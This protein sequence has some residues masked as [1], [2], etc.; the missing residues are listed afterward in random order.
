MGFA[1]KLIYQIDSTSTGL[2]STLLL[3]PPKNNFGVRTQFSCPL[4]SFL[5]ITDDHNVEAIS[6]VSSCLGL[7]LGSFPIVGLETHI[8]IFDECKLSALC[9]TLV[10]TNTNLLVWS[11]FPDS[12]T[13]IKL[14]SFLELL[15]ESVSNRTGMFATFSRESHAFDARLLSLRASLFDVT[16]STVATINE[17]QLTFSGSVKLYKKYRASLKVNIQQ[18]TDWKNA[19]IQVSGRFLNRP[20]N[21]PELLCEEISRYI[22]TLYHRS[23][24]RIINSKA[25]YDRAKS[26]YLSAEST[27]KTTEATMNEA[28]ELVQQTEQ[29]LIMIQNTVQALSNELRDGNTIVKSIKR[30]IESICNITQCPEICIPRQVCDEC[31][32][33]IS[34]LIQDTCSVPCTKNEIV[35]ITTGIEKKSRMEYVQQENCPNKIPCHVFIC[36]TEEHCETVHISKNITYDSPVTETIEIEILRTC[37]KPCDKVQVNTS[38]LIQCCKNVECADTKQEASCLQRNQQCKHTREVVYINLNE[39]ESATTQLLQSLDEAKANETVTKLRLTR[40][41]IRYQYCKKQ[42]NQSKVALN[43]A[44]TTLNVAAAS[45]KMIRQNNQLDLLDYLN[46]KSIILCSFSDPSYINIKS[47]TFVTNITTES[48]MILA[49]NIEIKIS[50]VR[51]T[52]SETIYLDFDRFNA[53]LKQAVLTIVNNVILNQNFKSKHHRRNIINAS[54]EDENYLH[55]QGQCSDIKNI[56]TYLRE[57]NKSITTIATTAKS[58]LSSLSKNMQEI[59]ALINYTTTTI[60]HENVTLDVETIATLTNRTRT[61]LNTAV[62]IG[63][64]QEIAEVLKLMEEHLFNGQ[65]RA[66]MLDENLFQSWQAKMEL[67]H[68]DTKS[69]AGF[70]CFGF[71]DC[72]QEVVEKL[73]E[74]ISEVPMINIEIISIV[75]NAAED[76]L[77]LA[78]LQNYSIISAQNK[79]HSIYKLA[80]DP[81]LKNYWC[82]G[83]PVI[84]SI[85]P[86]KRTNP[87]EN[88]AVVLSCEVEVQEH[89]SY[90][91]RKDCIQIPNQRNNELLLT[92]LKL[93]DSGNY[94]CVVTNQVSSVTSTNISVEV[95]QFPSFFLQPENVDEFLGN[96]NGAV[97]KS[98]ATG[99]PYP[100]YRWYFQPKG[101]LGFTRM[102]GEDQNELSIVPPLPKHEGSYYCEAFNEQGVVRS[103]IVNLTVLQPTVAQVAQTVYVNFTYLNE[104]EKTKTFGSGSGLTITEIPSAEFSGSGDITEMEKFT[105][106]FT[107]SSGS[108]EDQVKLL[109]SGINVNITITPSTKLMLERNLVNVLSVLMSFESTLVQN[110]TFHSASPFTL[111]TSFTLYSKNIDYSETSLSEINQL[112]SQARLEWAA[113]WK[114]LQEVLSVSGFIISD[115]S[116]EFESNASSLRFDML[117]FVC[118]A[119]KAISPIN[120]LLCGK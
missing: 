70:S 56:L 67:L 120:N 65:Q 96:Q 12:V 2:F 5:F 23:Q 41:K 115:D 90:Q 89:V 114:E 97:I 18:T 53:S 79:M 59:S 82:A 15:P 14:G 110:I 26:Q 22:E 19:E 6:I 118:P 60:L 46:N 71:P 117:Q 75:P 50:S 3:V 36:H 55:F 38:L 43:D 73:Q 7:R 37:N 98:N 32:Q 30:R 74:M 10:S 113:V 11:T 35:T 86:I 16:F 51:K 24:F 39:E 105:I 103:K 4:D 95:Q 107:E 68:N 64:S 119:G 83:P 29:E 63:E 13:A 61:S 72:L 99:F 93:S 62:D 94:T 112:A 111:A 102:P 58:S 109:G 8:Y 33:N 20:G 87:R 116:Y 49:V 69:A 84:K 40:S 85:R 91:W 80:N 21:I 81:V 42:F 9:S 66:N 106:F 45:Y 108:G 17:E 44:N 48:P 76:L 34:A 104:L 78:I 47:M 92:N 54:P 28:N 57:L 88:T 27:Y 100:G 77:D 25:A 31:Q 1:L 52:I 101:T